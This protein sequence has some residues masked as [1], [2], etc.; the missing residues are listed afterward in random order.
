MNSIRNFSLNLQQRLLLAFLSMSFLVLTASGISI[1]FGRSV[2]EAIA[3]SRV[4]LDQIQSVTNTQS[5]WRAISEAVDTLFLT[6]Q[7]D[8]ARLSIDTYSLSLNNQLQDLQE[9]QL[10][11]RETTIA[12]N[13]DILQDILL[14]KST[15]DS[16]IQEMLRLA[17]EGRWAVARD[18]RESIYTTQQTDFEN[19]FQQLNSNLRED[20]SL[21]FDEAKRLQDFTR[22]ITALISICAL[23]IALLLSIGGTRSIVFP[24]RQ[25]TEAVQRV[26][27]G[28]FKPFT[29]L[30]RKDEIGNLSRS[31]ALMTEWLR[32]SYERLEERVAERTE[33]LERQNVQISVAAEIAKEV[34][35]AR[36]PDK[37]LS[38]AVDL[39]SQRFGYY[40]TRIYLVD[41][42]GEYAIL[43]AASNPNGED[44]STE[45]LQVKVGD[46]GI[47]G[48]AVLTGE[49]KASLDIAQDYVF[50]SG[51]E[52]IE[53]ISEIVLPM[54]VGNLVIGAMDVKSHSTDTFRDSDQYVLQILA[55][56]LAVAIHN[57]QLNLKVEENLQ[58]LETL[59]GH[60]SRKSWEQVNRSLGIIGYTYDRRGVLPIQYQHKGRQEEELVPASIPLIVRGQEIG[61]LKVWPGE[62][63]LITEDIRVLEELGTRISQTLENAR[64]F[65]ETQRR[66]ENER[67]VRQASAHMR[68]TLD[69][70]NVLRVAAEDIFQAL[71]LSQVT[72]DLAPEKEI[73]HDQ[74]LADQER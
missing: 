24:V 46:S 4:G 12:N 25:L 17:S 66:A 53:P 13:S 68:E 31:F 64:L 72:I 74:K 7:V 20:V 56:L 42:I 45:A 26:T 10:G 6:R 37:L 50:D 65:N 63:R 59:Y 43:K 47:I 33:E 11:I 14:V 49:I 16:T 52:L 21:S 57:V 39:V 3:A 67:I 5:E 48:Q 51:N 36:D 35:T 54:K 32:D 73:F 41:E 70:E 71:N 40:Q 30:V 55:D 44:T 61:A 60:Y 58:E 9:Q 29:P 19:K 8:S 2:E 23:L 28:D 69:L 1:Y 62:N 18:L 34:S 38:L 27:L 15:I 22:F